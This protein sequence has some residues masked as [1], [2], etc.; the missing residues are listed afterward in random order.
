MK[1]RDNKVAENKENKD[2]ERGGFSL[3]FGSALDSNILSP[4][5]DQE[6]LNFGG[7]F[8]DHLYQQSFVITNH[9]NSQVF[10]F[11]W[12]PDQHVCFSPQVV[13]F[14]DLHAL[15]SFYE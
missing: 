4:P 1:V 9:S 12:P 6:V 3:S 5:G 14:T 13:I 2:W 11:E 15:S 8:V 10:K 7:C